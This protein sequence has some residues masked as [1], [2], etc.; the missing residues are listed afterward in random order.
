MANYQARIR[1][2]LLLV[3][4]RNTSVSLEV[5]SGAGL[6]EPT[7]GTLTVYDADDEVIV[8]AQA[9][10]ITN[11]VGGTTVSAASIPSTLSLSSDWRA[12]WDF[13]ISGGSY[14]FHQ[15]AQLVRRPWIPSVVQADLLAACPQMSN[16]YDLNSPIDCENLA[17]I[18]QA[19][20]EDVQAKLC[21]DGRRPQLIVE[22][23]H[24]N[25]YLVLEALG[26]IFRAHLFDQESSNVEGLKT[27]AAQYESQA[28]EAW[29]GLNFRYDSSESGK[30]GD[31]QQVSA[32]ATV[33]F[34]VTR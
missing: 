15:S 6:A 22:G 17:T 34:G 25:R 18:I 14:L 32:P 4:G 11:R 33:R 3:R 10:T 31:A 8:N 24:L 27:L 2:P 12:E 20:A 26:R 23:H 19:V 5:W 7:S 13:T 16:E 1:A 29:D 30:G 9:L 28:S 21:M